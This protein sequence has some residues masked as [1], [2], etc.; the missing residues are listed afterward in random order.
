MDL[1]ISHVGGPHQR[2]KV[3]DQY[4]VDH[5]LA[6][7]TANR[8]SFYP[9][10]CERRGILFVKMRTCNTVGETL[11]RDWPIP[12]MRQNVWRDP[13]VEINDL[14]LSE[15]VL[16]EKY[17]VQVREGDFLFPNPNRSRSHTQILTRASG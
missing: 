4:V 14:A 6:G 15:A 10:R 9:G 11:E 1:E 7:T 12:E 13:P 8:K 3:V 17:F 5:G 16:R 2:W